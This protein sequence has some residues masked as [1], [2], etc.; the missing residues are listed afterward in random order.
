MDQSVNDSLR[1]TD[2]DVELA[3][4]NV[5]SIQLSAEDVDAAG[6]QGPS[7]ALLQIPILVQV[8]LG[9]T[10]MALS[11]VM[12]LR[13]GSIITLDQRLS[14]PVRLLVNGNEFARGTIVVI[15][16]ASGQLG[17]TLTEITPGTTSI[18]KSG[19]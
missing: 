17:V 6:G 16:E 11:K 7:G 18:K 1:H 3:I 19:Q 10:T 4:P 14:E 8:I 15:D 12:A 9:S 2:S 13:R 5:K